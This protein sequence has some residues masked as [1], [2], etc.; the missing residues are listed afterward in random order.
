MSRK[1]ASPRIKYKLPTGPE[2]KNIGNEKNPFQSA[3]KINKEV[4][5]QTGQIAMMSEITE[6]TPTTAPTG[7]SLGLYSSIDLTL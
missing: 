2:G 6:I 4:N 1:S 5:P 7:I 3:T